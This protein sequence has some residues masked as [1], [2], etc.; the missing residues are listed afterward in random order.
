[1]VKAVR[2]ETMARGGPEVLS[3]VTVTPLFGAD[4]MEVP[5]IEGQVFDHGS[6]YST[7][8]VNRLLKF[9]YQ[10]NVGDIKRHV[11]TNMGIPPSVQEILAN[12]TPLPDSAIVEK[13]SDLRVSTAL[14]GGG[15]GARSEY[16]HVLSIR[17]NNTC[18]GVCK[19]VCLAA[20]CHSGVQ[21]C[22]RDP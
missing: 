6:E 15:G 7:Y 21:S 2:S 3:S 8:I 18:F 4:P 19:I 16:E 5:I 20:A 22:Y 14:D 10:V 13:N 17:Y 9:Y 11:Q 12:G 1:M